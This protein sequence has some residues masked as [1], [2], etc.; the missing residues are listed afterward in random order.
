MFSLALASAIGFLFV[1]EARSLTCNPVLL[2]DEWYIA[3]CEALEGHFDHPAIL[4][5]IDGAFSGAKHADVL[6]LGNS[7][8]QVAFS[9]VE[10]VGF[11][12]GNN[13]TFFL[14]GFGYQEGWQFV[15]EVLKR[16]ALNPEVLVLNIGGGW[17]LS[18][19]T[20]PRARYILEHPLEVYLRT[21]IRSV[22]QRL[23]RYYCRQGGE[24]FLCFHS[25]TVLYRSRLNGTWISAPTGRYDA[26]IPHRY[27]CEPKTDLREPQ[28]CAGTGHLLY[29]IEIEEAGGGTIS[30]D[31]MEAM[32][33]FVG[34]FT[35]PKACVIVTAVP[36]ER[37]EAAKARYFAE[38]LGTS[39]VEVDRRG[40]FTTDHTHLF[41]GSAEVYSRRFLSQI[42]PLLEFC[43]DN[44]KQSK[45][46]ARDPLLKSAVVG[47]PAA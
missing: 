12:K 46:T 42:Q 18:A 31:E 33:S 24:Q 15:D 47:F 37:N 23:Q 40:L 2:S 11:F 3:N 4:F 8:T 32:K 7:S 20:S 9:N 34:K 36:I 26:P 29:P 22:Y 19:L 28:L 27:G 45:S 21:V 10:T 16:I 38:Q 43:K 13:S 25:N 30:S 44:R 6:F 41:I 35:L 17:S 39:F 5:N 14:L 1:G